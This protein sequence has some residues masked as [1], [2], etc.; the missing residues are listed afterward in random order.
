MATRGFNTWRWQEWGRPGTSSV[1]GDQKVVRYNWTGS[2]AADKP[3]HSWTNALIV[4][5][6]EQ[7]NAVFNLH[8]YDVDGAGSY[9]YRTITGG[10]VFSP[11]AWALAVDINPWANPY[12]SMPASGPITDIPFDLVKD[13]YRIVTKKSRQRVWKWGGDW[14]GDWRFD[15]HTVTDAMHFEVIATPEELAEGVEF[16]GHI[17]VTVEVPMLKR[18]DRGNAVGKFQAALNSWMEATSRNQRI[19][20]DRIYG[21]ATEEWVKNYQ[22]AAQVTVTGTIDGVTAALLSDYFPTA[23]STTVDSE[24][25]Q[26]AQDAENEAVRARGKAEEANARLDALKAAV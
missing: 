5:A 13:A 14:D 25:R 3:T 26:M 15:D 21:P 1:D 10:T 12:R 8:G 17:P 4:P 19:E 6:L 16:D 24:A 7:L 9:N 18:G 2:T 11:H 22:T 20:V 23:T